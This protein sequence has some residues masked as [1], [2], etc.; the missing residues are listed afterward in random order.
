MGWLDQRMTLSKSL[1]LYMVGGIVA[2]FTVWVFTRNL[3]VSWMG[4]LANQKIPDYEGRIEGYMWYQML[5]D[6]EQ[7]LTF[8]MLWAVYEF[9]L[10]FYLTA[11]CI[12]AGRAFLKRKINPAL[13]AV[14]ASMEYMA[15]GDYGHEIAYLAADEMGELCRNVDGI[16]AKLVMEKKSQWISEEKQRRINAAFAH[17]MRTPLTVI[18]GCTE[19]LQRY[20][21]KGKVSEEL[22]LEKL[23]VMEH[24]EQRLL[25]LSGTMTELLREEA[26]VVQGAWYPGA[27]VA[28]ALSQT[29][30]E[31]ARQNEFVCRIR[32]QKIDGQVFLDR[33]L[34]EEV[35]DN[36][37]AN[38]VRYA[39]TQIAVEFAKSG[40]LF[41]IYVTDDGPGFS[42]KA[43]VSGA[44][45]YFSEEKEHGEHFGIGL[46]ICK[47][48]CEKHGGTLKLVNS[49]DGGAIACA[50]FMTGWDYRRI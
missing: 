41:R 2:A 38:A 14:R 17:D 34:V 31:L 46:S 35:F 24:Q 33:A 32:G 12:A 16:R 30:E 40:S 47:M 48:L 19:F 10:Y 44:D 45:A 50:E 13:I 18:K 8:C 1:F 21:P 22:L 15:A 6:T 37:L 25:E 5:V 27:E 9:S 4:V 20:V 39:S 29:A 3:C 28:A 23:S 7:S 26:R 49:I 36:L 11:A 43:I 42:A